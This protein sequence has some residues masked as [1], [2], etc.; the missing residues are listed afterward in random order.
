MRGRGEVMGGG[1]RRDVSD[2]RGR[3]GKMGVGWMRKA[4]GGERMEGA[5]SP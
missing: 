2:E 5:G 4:G 1:G 3:G